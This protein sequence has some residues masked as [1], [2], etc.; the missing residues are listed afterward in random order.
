[1][2]VTDPEQ[3]LECEQHYTRCICEEEDMSYNIPEDHH[4]S[5]PMIPRITDKTEEWDMRDRKEESAMPEDHPDA[6]SRKG[7]EEIGQGAD[8][9]GL[10]FNKGKLRMDLTPPEWEWALAD[11]TT[12]GSKKYAARNWEKGM[13]WS[14]M[15]GCM[16][17]HI[18]KFLAGERYDG[19]DFNLEEGTTGCHHLAMVAWNAL[20]LMS[21]DLRE[22][23]NND[24]P[25][26][27]GMASLKRVNAE[28]SDMGNDVHGFD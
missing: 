14:T 15:V 21:Y 7:K 28:T 13:D 26:D 6:L 2:S 20:A 12:Q 4:E 22:L 25:R 18:N 17:R 10:R 5:V 24:L 19:K 8:G 11:V 23:G 27:T 3:C 9:G 1:M 16:K